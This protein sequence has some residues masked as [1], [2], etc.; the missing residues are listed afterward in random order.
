MRM[1]DLA[2][3]FLACKAKRNMISYPFPIVYKE[4]SYWFLR[5]AKLFL[6]FAPESNFSY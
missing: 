5:E 1:R 2:L 3:C 4:I 6:A